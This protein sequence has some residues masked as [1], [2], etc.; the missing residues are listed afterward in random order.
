MNSKQIF[1]LA[2]ALQKPWF[3]EDIKMSVPDGHINGVVDIYLNFER[4][5]YFGRNCTTKTGFN[6]TTISVSTIPLKSV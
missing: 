1:E 2:L 6:C 3:I 4:G 5:E